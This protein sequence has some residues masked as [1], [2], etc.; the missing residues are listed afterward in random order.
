MQQATI[1]IKGL[2]CASCAEKIEKT[3]RR[4]KGIESVSVYLGPEK[5]EVTFD[6]SSISQKRIERAIETLGY[7]VVRNGSP[8]GPG[9]STFWRMGFV[10][11]LIVLGF[12]GL[13][14][15]IVSFDVFS[16]AAIIIG[17]YPLFRHAARDILNKNIT[18]EVFMALGVATATAIGEF[19]S[20]AIIAFFMLISEYI[21][22][23]TMEKSRRAIK[24]LINLAPKTAR[25]RR[26]KN[27]IEV[28]IEEVKK[29]EVVI[30]RP[31][32]KIPVEGVIISGRGAVSE[33][34]ITGESFPVEK[35][36][37]DAVFAATINQ[38]GLLFIKVLHTGEDTT[39]ARIIRLV[40]EAESAKAPVQKV[41][42]KFASYFTPVII[43]I[44]VATYVITGEIRNAI[45]VMVVACPCSVA[46]AT[47]L[48]V[49]AS[50]GTAA[51][52]GIIIKGG[53]Y[54]E[55][56]AKVDTLVVDKTGTLTLGNPVVTDIEG[57]GST[58]REEVLALA[59][60]IEKYSEH[61]LAGAILKEAS[62]RAMKVPEPDKSLVL[63]G[64][65]IVASVH[66]QMTALG[67]RELMAQ[68]G[69][70][71]S[72]EV[73]TYCRRR[74]DEG[75]T[76]LMLADEEKITGVI[77]V[78]DIIREGT[79]EAMDSLR[80]MGFREPVMLTGDN[81][82]TASMVAA[83][84]GIAKVMAGLLPQDK[85]EQIRQLVSEG[86]RVVMV[87]DGINDAPALALSHVGISMGA[88]GSDVA[89]EASDV[90]LMRD[91]WKQVP[92]A[93]EIGRNTFAVIRQNLALG[94]VFNLVGIGLASTGVLSPTAAAVAHIMPDV[95]VFMNSSRL[96]KP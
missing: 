49:V 46:I 6:S 54:L 15:R 84:L 41:A 71:I 95:L 93:I 82:R 56:L 77:C 90:A 5:V 4:E 62:A 2:D 17:G 9:I 72:G 60:S 10:L 75:K 36:E 96:L 22:S 34:P 11:F 7:K 61:P 32:E 58:S 20:A 81:A 92:Q 80:E 64:M 37:G 12:T 8:A 55:A 44:A 33:A 91:E 1:K 83:H 52:K 68:R 85:V 3:L 51:R 19:R 69:I 76:A 39:Y 42:D 65:G 48:A 74:E 35:K 25:V 45:A 88:A 27:E 47:P 29:G 78:A 59:A 31:G 38:M 94:I 40:E 18:A 50:M 67:N 87:G 53:R 24:E 16:M 79:I 66:K 57:F 86:K 89:I 70:G 14:S 28:P 23:F 26:G 13:S 21:D 63:P 73:E 30:V 43:L